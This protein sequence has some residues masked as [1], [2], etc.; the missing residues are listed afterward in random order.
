MPVQPVTVPDMTLRRSS[1]PLL[2]GL[3]ICLVAGTIAA[4]SATAS[5]D[6]ESSVVSGLRGHGDQLTFGGSAPSA[7]ALVSSAE[8]NARISAVLPTRTTYKAVGKNY[9]VDVVDV[10]SGT[11]L[12]SRRLTT[13]LLPASN[14]K[15]VTAV[16]ALQAMGPDKTFTTRVVSLGKGKVAIIGGGDATLSRAGLTKLA[17]S[18][19]AAINARPDL[20]PDVSTP[21][22]YRPATCIRKGKRVKSTAK[23]PCPLVRPGPRRAVKVYVDDSLYPS[24]V[25]PAGWR[26]G[27]EPSVVRPVRP[28]GIDGDY[29]MDSSANAAAV[30]GSALKSGGLSGSFAGRA[31]GAGAEQLGSYA[32]AKLSDQVKYML[33]VSENNVAEMLYRNTAIA[34]GYSPT[35]AN[36]ARA[37]TESLVA[38]G[39]PMGGLS[40]TS[41]SGVGRNDRLTPLALTSILQR[42]ADSHTY[43]SLIPVYYGGGL[44][45]AGRTGTLSAGARRFTTKPSKCAA[46]RL[47]A[48]TGTL[49]DT[50]SLSGL[51]TGA[52][53][54]LKAFSVLVNSRP[55]KYSPLQTRQSVDRMAATVT[56]C[57]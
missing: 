34:K 23:K 46:G 37:A 4:P 24:P 2:A 20:L 50:V 42:V 10:D 19:A 36:S 29:S 11:R 54:R 5:S 39:I 47:R 44:P 1:L 48:K 35:W 3:S 38:L 43:P 21:A 31:S 27:Y 18:T 16:N 25:R 9:A 56:G 17:T 8:A 22:P 7:R 33:Q 6:T 14:M 55:Q 52:D 26:G 49:S 12:W 15:I 32:G 30:F 41:G 28:L 51:A 57:Y 45:L 13:P 53:G 40:L